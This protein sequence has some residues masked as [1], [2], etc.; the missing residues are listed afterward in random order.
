MFVDAVEIL[1]LES[2]PDEAAFILR[3]L[4]LNKFTNKVHLV[5]NTLEARSFM[6]GSNSN[7]GWSSGDSAK[8]LILGNGHSTKNVLLLIKEL[9]AKAN[10]NQVKSLLIVDCEDDVD[11]VKDAGYPTDGYV[12]RPLDFNR[13]SEAIRD[14]GFFWTLASSAP[15]N[16]PSAT[17]GARFSSN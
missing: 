17:V 10:A 6:L 5:R 1:L 16:L 9:Y 4:Q 2:Q 8:I 12:V 7:A 14:L 15:I 11:R 3:Q 13:F